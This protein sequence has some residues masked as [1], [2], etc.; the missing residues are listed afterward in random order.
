MCVVSGDL[1]SDCSKELH[2][3]PTWRVCQDLLMVAGVNVQLLIL[4][5]TD[6]V[7]RPDGTICS[8]E[9]RPDFS[10]LR[11]IAN[12]METIK[13]E[14]TCNQSHLNGFALLGSKICNRQFLFCLLHIY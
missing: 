1:G 4:P 7:A 2:S 11:Y 12:F 10:C 6:N 9:V 13:K 5:I 8:F 14:W 3:L